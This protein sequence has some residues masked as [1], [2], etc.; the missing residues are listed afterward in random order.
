MH[1]RKYQ[2]NLSSKISTML[3]YYQ[4]GGLALVTRKILNKTGLLSWNYKAKLETI[5]QCHKGKVIIIVPP[6]I[7]WNIPLYQR[8][9]HLAT[10]LAKQGFLYFFCTI[11]GIYEEINGF[12]EVS[13][14]CYVTDQLELLSRIEGK[15]IHL[16]SNDNRNLIP[17]IMQITKNCDI[18]LYDYI[19]EIHEDISRTTIS[20]SCIEKHKF[21]IN[22][23]NSIVTTSA[24]KLTENVLNINP[25]KAPILVT[26]GVEVEH[27]STTE[28]IG[29]PPDALKDI[30]AS[31]DKIVG[32]FGAM[33]KW[34]DY[35]LVKKIAIE[36]EYQICLIGWEYDESLNKSGISDFENI[37]IIG[38]VDY[39][40]LPNYARYFNVAIIPFLINEITESTSPI[41]LFEYMALQ[42]PIVTTDL[43]ECRKYESAIVAIN[44]ADFLAKLR[45]AFSLTEDK[46]Y[47]KILAKE[48]NE[49]SWINKAKLIA[50]AINL[51]SPQ[52]KK[53]VTV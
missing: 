12:I 27:F 43:P 21:L 44:H 52:P 17:Q 42:K 9:Q 3:R 26:N 41:K 50:N 18:L 45:F 29:F 35:E 36:K 30:I 48:A 13:N 28:N 46:E 40:V 32:Y 20:N 2:R 19:D 47:L 16:Y 34:F 22:H 8:P 23:P 14:G 53:Q 6:F 11:D 33:A 1:N 7:A 31:G 37:H 49:N 10:N 5:L 24:T 39:R 4:R 25:K 51:A 38:S 15:V